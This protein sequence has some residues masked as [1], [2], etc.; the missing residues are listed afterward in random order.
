MKIQEKDT[1]HGAALTQIVEHESFK[2]LNK[3]DTKYGHYLVNTDRRMMVKHTKADGDKWRFTFQPDDLI[4]LAGDLRA[5]N[6]VFVVLVCG[7]STICC[8]DAA[9][10]QVVLDMNDTARAQWV[11]TSCPVV[12]GSMRAKGTNGPLKG[13]IPH[14]R[15]PEVVLA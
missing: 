3:A 1:Y 15:F 5:T 6:Y 10:I 4:V 14:N 7:Q 2:A 9:Q 8:L 11:E 12:G 13:T